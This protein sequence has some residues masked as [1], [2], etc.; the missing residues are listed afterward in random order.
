MV[1]AGCSGVAAGHDRPQIICS[2]ILLCIGTLAPT[3]SRIAGDGCT[4]SLIMAM[5]DACRQWLRVHLQQASLLCLVC[6]AMSISSRTSPARAGADKLKE[7]LSAR[8]MKCGGTPEQ[9]AERLFQCRGRQLHELP[10]NLFTKGAVPAAALDEAARSKRIQV[11]QHTANIEAKVLAVVES[12]GAVIEDTQAWVEKKLA[13]N[14]DEL[15]QDIE[16]EDF[17]VGPEDSDEEVCR[18]TV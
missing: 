4:V 14:Y 10:A 11:A 15:K 7:A 16:R 1:V 18:V 12:L 9:R 3:S 5:L 6:C 8:N 2:A 13:Q 17:D